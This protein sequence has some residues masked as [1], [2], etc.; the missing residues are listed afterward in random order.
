MQTITKGDN[1]QH[2]HEKAHELFIQNLMIYSTKFKI[3]LKKIEVINCSLI[4]CNIQTDL[5]LIKSSAVY[6]EKT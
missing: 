1:M 5:Q 4:K 2:V 6:H 3:F